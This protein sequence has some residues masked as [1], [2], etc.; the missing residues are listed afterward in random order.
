M[1]PVE[2]AALTIP[3]AV[4]Y[5]GLARSRLYVLAA[6]GR[7]TIRRA[8]RRSV[9]LRSDID[10]LLASLPAAPIGRKTAA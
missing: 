3:A 9:I 6:E 10:A 2:P 5:S 7:L 4:A 1:T 8:G